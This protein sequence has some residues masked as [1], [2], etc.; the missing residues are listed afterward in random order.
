MKIDSDLL[1]RFCRVKLVALD[2]DGV[3]TDGGIIYGDHGDEI[4]RF[5]IQ[6]GLGIAVLHRLKIPVVLITGRTSKVNEKRAKELKVLHLIQ[7]KN[8][9]WQ[10]LEKLLMQQ[11]IEPREV[12]YV[13]DDLI[14][15]QS[16]LR[17]GVACAV[18]NAVPDVIDVAHYVTQRDGGHGAVR[19]VIDIL[20]DA[21]GMRE[22]VIRWYTQDE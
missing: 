15:L 19:E 17:V 10:A 22:Q 14:D 5:D 11:Q 8:R 20:I 18:R 2:V 21:K 1:D 7:G 12:C 9:K 13:G 3:L 4:K 16:M 6:D